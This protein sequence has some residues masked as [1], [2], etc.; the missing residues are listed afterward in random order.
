MMSLNCKLTDCSRNIMNTGLTM[1][2]T[3]HQY[4]K[5]VVQQTVRRRRRRQWPCR[6]FVFA[7]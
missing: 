6:K 1:S 2:S 7:V 4:V 3:F 5:F